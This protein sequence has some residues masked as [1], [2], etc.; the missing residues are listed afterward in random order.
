MNKL[1]NLEIIFPL[2]QFPTRLPRGANAPAATGASTAGALHVDQLRS[3]MVNNMKR[4][5]LG[6]IT[7]I[8]LGSGFAYAGTYT[9]SAHGGSSGVDRST[10]SQYGTGNCAHCHEQHASI[11]GTEP[12]PNA[13]PADGPDN[14]LLFDQ[15]HYDQTLNF[16][17]DC[18]KDGWGSYQASTNPTR[19]TNYSYS[20]LFGGDTTACPES[21]LR[22]FSFINEATGASV[23]NCGVT[24]GSSHKLTDIGSFVTD[25]SWGYTNDSNPCCGCHNP[26][27]AKVPPSTTTASSP[28]SL[29]SAHANKYTWGIYS[30]TMSNYITSH[31]GTYQPPN[32]VGGGTELDASKL[33]D[34]N[35][36]CTDCHI[37]AITSNNYWIKND[38]IESA[39][40]TIA[41]DWGNSVHGGD[42]RKANKIEAPYSTSN[43]NYV[44]ACTDCH[45]PHG[46]PNRYL[47]RKAVNGTSSV[48][49]TD[50]SRTKWTTLC[51]RCHYTTHHSKPCSNCH[52]H[53]STY[54]G[55]ITF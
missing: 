6:L 42:A 1:K 2:D 34:Y 25:K 20:K 31:G 13:D 24:T 14:Y 37:D 28:I 16:C 3:Y 18:H 50:N 32:K 36:F 12:A 9:D 4:I 54:S 15:N 10:T 22:A 5:F 40:A 35:T 29:P 26:H 51:D 49:L 52:Y 39:T 27:A 45:E 8:F 44:L 48:A 30:D 41:I 33:P 17:F 21:I 7:L 11:N 55:K 23:S 38:G 47:I 43:S 19:R 53:G 46:S